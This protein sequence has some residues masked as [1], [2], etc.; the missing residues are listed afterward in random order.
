MA[1]ATIWNVLKKTKDFI[2]G[3]TVT[4][5]TFISPPEEETEGR[6]LPKQTTTEKA[7]IQTTKSNTKEEVGFFGIR[8]LLACRLRPSINCINLPKFNFIFCNNTFAH[9][10]I[11][12]SA[13]KR[14]DV[15]SCFTNLHVNSRGKKINLYLLI[16]NPKYMR[17]TKTTLLNLPF[18]YFL[19]QL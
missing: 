18:Q 9:Q 7:V 15:L 5:L 16:S 13:T 8:K 11:G 6:N 17:I 4:Q 12:W 10:N 19:R 3:K 1:S 14:Y 2:G